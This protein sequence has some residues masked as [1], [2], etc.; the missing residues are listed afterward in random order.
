MK[1][2]IALLT[3]LTLAAQPAAD[4]KA[5]VEI[6]RDKWGVPHIYAQ[7]ADDLFFAQG[8]VTAQLEAELV[9]EIPPGVTI[10]YH[11]EPLRGV[12]QELRKL[13]I[14]LTKPGLTD[15]TIAFGAHNEIP[16]LG[17]RDRVHFL[18][19]CLQSH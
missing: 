6:L 19:S 10:D 7:N 16:D 12:P 11:P 8:F 17:G 1:L 5:P 14:T 13:R 15:L 4:L 18:L 2:T 9:G 3:G